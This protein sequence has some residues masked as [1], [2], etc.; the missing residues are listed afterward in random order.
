M[1]AGGC[2]G[3]NRMQEGGNDPSLIGYLSNGCFSGL[4]APP[5]DP[6]KEHSRDGGGGAEGADLSHLQVMHF[7]LNDPK[8]GALCNKNKQIAS[9]HLLYCLTSMLI[10]LPPWRAIVCRLPDAPV[11][12]LLSNPL[13]E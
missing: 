12:N 7:T 3:Q 2:E 8:C 10:Y 13:T 1:M 5:L 11:V 9:V 6:H 4:P